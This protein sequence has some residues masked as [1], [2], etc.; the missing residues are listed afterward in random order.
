MSDSPESSYLFM[1]M[2]KQQMKVSDLSKYSRE[3]ADDLRVFNRIATLSKLGGLLTFSKLQPNTLRIEALVH[4][5]CLHS[6]GLR[7]PS[8]YD[9]SRW[10]NTFLGKPSFAHMEDP[11]EDV[12]VSNVNSIRGNHRI[13][14]GIWDSN[15]FWLQQIID[16]LFTI[17]DELESIRTL[18][19][20]VLALLKLS[21]AVANRADASLFLVSD[22]R[23]KRTIE[24]PDDH[25][26]FDRMGAVIFSVAD[27]KK[28]EVEINDFK[29][30]I[31]TETDFNDFGSQYLENSI[32]QRR[33]LIRDQ[34]RLILILPPAVS[35]AIRLHVLRIL[36]ENGLLK[37]FAQAL[38][39]KQG[40]EIFVDG[41][42]A[43]KTKPAPFELTEKPEGLPP[44]DQEVCSFDEG[45]FCHIVLLHDNLSDILERGV[46]S[47]NSYG[48]E[49]SK[50]LFFYLRDVAEKLSRHPDFT[51]GITIII[52]GGIG[53]GF[54]LGLGKFPE[55]WSNASFGLAHFSAIGGSKDVSLLKIWK[56]CQQ[57]N[58]IKQN[59]IDFS[60]V[61][62]FANIYAYW[63]NSN[64]RL[65]PPEMP[66]GNYKSLI[67]IPTNSIKD[68]RESVRQDHNKHAVLFQEPDLWITVQRV[69][70]SAYFRE[71]KHQSMY[72][73]HELLT[74]E[75]SLYGVIET[76][77]RGWWVI[78][79]IKPDVAWQ[80]SLLHQIWECYLLWM[81]KL[82][83]ILE[84]EVSEFLKGPIHF[85]L[86]IHELSEFKEPYFKFIGDGPDKPLFEIASWSTI[87][88]ILPLPFL[89]LFNRPDNIAERQLLSIAIQSVF[90]LLNLS[91]SQDKLEN[92]IKSIM[93]NQEIRHLHLF[94]TNNIIEQLRSYNLPRP[95]YVPEEDEKFIYLG[96]SWNILPQNQEKMIINGNT[97]NNFLHKIVDVLWEK[98]DKKLS[99]INRMSI[100]TK[101]LMNL[102]TLE[103]DKEEWKISAQALMAI[104][105]DRSD[106]IGS[107]NRLD[108]RRSMAAIATRSLAEMAVCC[109]PENGKTVS[110]EDFQSLLAHIS[111]LVHTGYQSDAIHD[112]MIN[113]EVEVWPN[114]E[115][116]LNQDFYEFVVMPYTT[117][118]F[119]ENFK[120]AADLYKTR[121]DKNRS[122]KNDEENENEE[123]YSKGFVNA[124]QAEYKISPSNVIDIFVELAT[125]AG[126]HDSLV[127]ETPRSVIINRLKDTCNLS[128]EQVEYFFEKFSL[129]PRPSWPIPPKG[130]KPKDIYPWKFR[131]ALSLIAR[132]F[133]SF[134]KD[135][136]SPI[137]Y[138][139]GIMME[140]FSILLTRAS[141]G[142][143]PPEYFESNE[144]KS[145]I[146]LINNELGNKFTDTVGGYFQDKGWKTRI[147]LN[148]TEFGAPP[149]LGDIDILAWDNEKKRILLIECKR[150]I[151]ARTIG[152][153]GEQI[154]KF[155][156]ESGDE[157]SKHINRINWLKD[158][159][160]ALLKITASGEDVSIEPWLI[161]N[162]LVPFKFLENLPLE[163][164][165]IVSFNEIDSVI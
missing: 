87:K 156:G 162:T 99:S 70:P 16:I 110:L 104:Y 101:C 7:R 93:P 1:M 90:S 146:G 45:K 85:I 56:L 112:S 132:P 27:L 151:F 139:A 150:L 152:E 149:E 127:I 126:E 6:R 81:N 42:R 107:A 43:L 145:W 50:E 12:F 55:P 21:E 147:R 53:R 48:K 71:L 39:L 67:V 84:S 5:V 136:Q 29:P 98:I 123:I 142:Q 100:I 125:F 80:R 23:P 52:H 154:K 14:K 91:I 38:R 163:K 37:P 8:S 44:L 111:I 3:L 35:P 157:L 115:Y 32:L 9:F 141:T 28:I 40:H 24:L 26:I 130:F 64:F 46:A 54:V 10:I 96:I 148:M 88:I 155:R 95:I 2:Q 41:L 118:Y 22:G 19:S 60:D 128:I 47:F 75:G 120:L 76:D 86:N 15:D 65:I 78:V 109:C 63:H 158:N 83:P 57:V 69:F 137:I 30:F 102:E 97:A 13:F 114:G 62:G 33:P 144:M 135:A 92:I 66:F 161:T 160:E 49:I 105:N 108:N 106:V 133:L 129:S 58:Y 36:K 20:Q 68:L 94:E 116:S 72:A 89:K 143:I 59:G 140:C 51:G 61:S 79:D 138:A 18:K 25:E 119:A 153:I 124:F 73:S 164:K 131:R 17:P 31:L 121:Y 134:G 77:N 103:K 159:K 4:L 11:V 74:Q 113:P 122:A 117:G 165:Y 82:A 34:N